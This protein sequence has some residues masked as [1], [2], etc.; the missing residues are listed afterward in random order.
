VKADE[1]K[2]IKDRYDPKVDGQFLTRCYYV[3]VEL[4]LAMFKNRS[5][6]PFFQKFMKRTSLPKK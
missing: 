4:F 6:Y 2:D 3:Q 5:P 1:W